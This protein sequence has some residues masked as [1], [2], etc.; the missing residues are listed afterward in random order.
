[1][2]IKELYANEPAGEAVCTVTVE[3]VFEKG[4]EVLENNG[5]ADWMKE[6]ISSMPT[7]FDR[8]GRESVYLLFGSCAP[9][10]GNALPDAGECRI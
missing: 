8:T 1:M 9:P 3:D 7:D 6:R 2:E 5:I 4:T 10:Y